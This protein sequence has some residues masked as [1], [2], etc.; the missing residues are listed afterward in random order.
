MKLPFSHWHTLTAMLFAVGMVSLGAWGQVDDEFWFVA[1]E[2]TS[3]HGDSPVLLRF[4]TFDSPAE[5][6]VDMPANPLYAPY[7]LSIPANSA[8]SIDLTDSLSWYENQPFDQVHDKGLHITSSANISAYYEVNRY[9]NPDIFALKG[10]NALGYSFHLPFQ[11]FTSNGYP[12][13]PAAFD[14]VATE[15]NTILTITP[16]QDLVGHPAGVAYNI[17]LPLAG[18]TYSGRAAGT[19][20]AAHPVG[21]V[22]TANKP[23]ALTLS[24]DSC[25]GAIFGGCADLMGDQL[26]PDN[27]LGTEYIPIHGYLQGGNGDDRIQILATVNNTT[28]TIDGTEIVTIDAGEAY[29]HILDTPSSFIE[30][31]EPVAVWQSTGFGCELGGAQLPSVKCTGSTSVTFVRSTDEFIG[32][33]L[34][35]PAGGE[36][37]FSFNGDNALIDPALFEAVPGTDGAWMFAQLD[38]GVAVPILAPS[39]IENTSHVFHLGIIHGGASSGTRYGY[40]SDYGALKYQAVNQTVNVCFG[41]PLAL[42]VNPVENGLY[43]WTGPNAYSGQGISVELGTAI[44]PLAGEYVVQGYTGE[45]AIANDTITVVVHDPLGP[46]NVSDD[47]AS[48]VGE[49]ATFGATGGSISWS[50]P[51][52]FTF[53]GETVTLPNASLETEGYYVA[54]LNDPWCP[55]QSDSLFVDVLTDAELTLSW[56]EEKSFCAGEQGWVTLPG[57]LAQDNPSVQ[58]WWTPEGSMTGIPVSNEMSFLVSEGG[59][60]EAES[61]TEGPCPIL[62]NV[63]VEVTVVV[64][65]LLVPNVIT[66]GNDDFNNRFVVTNLAQ[67]PSST[68]R[69]FNRW[70]N[71]VY[72]SDD[73]GSTV[74]WLPEDN[75]SAGTY[76]YILHINRDSEQISVTTEHGTTEYVEPGP[77]DLHGSFMVVK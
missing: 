14:V 72:R 52:G 20:A 42:E 59:I 23:V 31:S 38:L 53:E 54:T 37:N 56:E 10:V 47:V 46:P 50:G 29:Q 33:N 41:E 24:D 2:V 9:N 3:Q 19:S 65:D 8:V 6:V 49:P 58:W 60:Y 69:I 45:C 67:F 22:V 36:A 75:V 62:G 5:V 12:A 32:I 63:T 55:N 40:F 76:Y 71:E 39:R 4:A 11:N 61:S 74:G 1:P 57:T 77:I 7:T 51:D 68:V 18:S 15:P 26:V 25:S 30:T 21:T 48:C 13:S 28:V 27:I 34:L 16:S 44:H 70:G 43:Q 73:F 17:V 35:V 66:P 64:C